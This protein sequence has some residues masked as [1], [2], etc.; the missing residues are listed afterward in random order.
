MKNFPN[1]LK[2]SF[3]V[4]HHFYL[5]PNKDLYILLVLCN[6]SSNGGGVLVS[7]PYD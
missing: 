1:S 3:P 7:A 4:R 6:Q 5:E 2:Y